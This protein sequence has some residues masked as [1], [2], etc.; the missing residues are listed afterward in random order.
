MVELHFYDDLE[1]MDVFAKLVKKG[2]QGNECTMNL[3]VEDLVGKIEQG[4]TI[5]DQP[6]NDEG[7]EHVNNEGEVLKISKEKQEGVRKNKERMSEMKVT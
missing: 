6:K 1:E 3:V 5:L 2:L 7:V 4:K